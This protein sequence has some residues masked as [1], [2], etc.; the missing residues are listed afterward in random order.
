MF[1]ARTNSRAIRLLVH[2]G[3]SLSQARGIAM[4]NSHVIMNRY[5]TILIIAG[6][7][8]CG[9][10]GIQADIKTCAALGVYASTAITAVTAQNT[11][12]VRD[13]MPVTPAVVQ[14]QMQAVLEDLQVDAV[15]IGMLCNAGIACA[16]AE[17]LRQYA[18]IPVILD[19]VM[20]ST[21]GHTLLEPAAVEAVRR[22][23]FPLATLLT[24]NSLEA[25]ML[26]GT[27]IAATGDMPAA[28]R[29]L[30]DD[31]CHAVLIKGGHLQGH[32]ATDMLFVPGSE[33]VAYSA[34]ACRTRNTHG[35]GCTLS[36]AIAA[37]VAL[38][39]SLPQAVG[40]AKEYVS[41][42]IACGARAFAGHGHGALNHAYAPQ[43]LVANKVYDNQ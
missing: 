33:L 14:A 40:A 20:L 11:L 3:K 27:E 35:T 2:P 24:P 23:L 5:P 36:S 25:S 22:E 31:G 30:M 1:V 39:H 6:S 43:P 32:E 7:D 4:R 19:P 34:P 38:G 12:G 42:A 21:S 16:V 18:G 10:A 17:V 8:S 29:R 9:G 26:A 28:A 37:F 15:K 41:H 13:V